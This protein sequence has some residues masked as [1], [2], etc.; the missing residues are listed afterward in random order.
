MLNLE[1]LTFVKIA[2]L[3]WGILLTGVVMVF[4][5]LILRPFFSIR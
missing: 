4:G 1:N 2:A 5:V 3:L